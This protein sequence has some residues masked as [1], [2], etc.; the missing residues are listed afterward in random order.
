MNVCRVPQKPAHAVATQQ[1]RGYTRATSPPRSPPE[2][3]FQRS[4]VAAVPPIRGQDVR[5]Y[6]ERCAAGIDRHRDYLT[7][8]DAVLGDGD[9]GDNMAIG[10]Q[11]IR[12]LLAGYPRE[13]VPGELLR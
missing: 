9:H 12:E 1:E 5:A 8:L 6:L 13:T 7:R 3:P 11:V 2:S 4:R 10:F